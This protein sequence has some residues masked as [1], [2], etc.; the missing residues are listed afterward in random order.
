MVTEKTIKF[1]SS[2]HKLTKRLG[3]VSSEFLLLWP[4]IPKGRNSGHV[5]QTLL[6]G[7]TLAADFGLRRHP[8]FPGIWKK[9][10]S[11]IKNKTNNVLFVSYLIFAHLIFSLILKLLS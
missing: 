6:E 7:L 5:E 4:K 9:V 3:A 11:K 10:S 8:D 1:H 2:I